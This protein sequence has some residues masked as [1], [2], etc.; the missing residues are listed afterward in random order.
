MQPTVDDEH[1][2]RRPGLVDHGRMVG[3]QGWPTPVWCAWADARGHAEGDARHHR[4]E[5][6]E[7][8]PD[9]G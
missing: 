4:P 3:G 5:G 7:A 8:R 1:G 2:P 9:D 6:Q